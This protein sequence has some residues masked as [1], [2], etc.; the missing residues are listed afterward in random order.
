MA[1]CAAEHKGIKAISNLCSSLNLEDKCYGYLR[2]EEYRYYVYRVKA[3]NPNVFRLST[4]D[5]ILRKLNRKERYLLALILASS[6][7]QLH[8]TPWLS[9]PWTKTDI[10][11]MSEPEDPNRFLFSQPHIHHNPEVTADT[12]QGISDHQSIFRHSP[13]DFGILLLELCFGRTLEDRQRTA[14]GDRFMEALDWQKEVDG[15]TGSGYSNAVL[16]CLVGYRSRPEKWR[17]EMFQTVVK[18][19]EMAYQYLQ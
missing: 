10:T 16:W 14:S 13:V 1:N 19:L 2:E 12:P 15:E 11:F 5:E 4:L 3:H 8:D 6:F 7:I 18:P 17:E 9:K